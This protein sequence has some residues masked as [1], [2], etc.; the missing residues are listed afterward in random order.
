M[1]RTQGVKWK[2][3]RKRVLTTWALISQLCHEVIVAP[4]PYN[5]QKLAFEGGCERAQ[6][7]EL[8]SAI[9]SGLGEGNGTAAGERDT[10]DAGGETEGD[11]TCNSNG[12]GGEGD[13]P[14]PASASATDCR[15]RR[16][17]NGLWASARLTGESI[18]GC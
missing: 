12:E 1:D 3:G 16:F 6:L 2:W 10:D 11:G 15:E 4:R 14:R 17:P 7:T 8:D 18:F 9:S 5:D 13:E